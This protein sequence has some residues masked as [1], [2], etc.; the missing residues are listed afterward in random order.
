MPGFT[1]PYLKRPS[2]VF[3][4]FSFIKSMFTCS[5]IFSSQSITYVAHKLGPF[6]VLWKV[7]EVP[8]PYSILTSAFCHFAHALFVIFASSDST[9][10]GLMT[11][12]S[13]SFWAI[14]R[15]NNPSAKYVIIIFLKITGIIQIISINFDFINR[16]KS[17]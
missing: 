12:S 11:C 8:L 5:P 2:R 10:H 14:G 17:H 15:Y 1:N 6:P 7:K 3:L 16:K 13:P 4:P 9:S